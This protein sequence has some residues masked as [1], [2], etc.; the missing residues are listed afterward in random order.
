MTCRDPEVCGE[1]CK[2]TGGCSQGNGIPVAT[3]LV[4]DRLGDREAHILHHQ[5]GGPTSFLKC[6]GIEEHLQRVLSEPDGF[7]RLKK[8]LAEQGITH[9]RKGAGE[10][11]KKAPKTIPATGKDV[12]TDKGLSLLFRLED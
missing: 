4:D 11:A 1:S 9:C 2:S 7:A 6:S 3:K 5:D 8:A 10:G 12:P